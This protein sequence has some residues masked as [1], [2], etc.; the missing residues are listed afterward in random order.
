MSGYIPDE[1]IEEI[2]S[3]ADIREIVSAFVTLQKRGKYYTGLC[4]FHGEKKPSFTVNVERQ[5]FHCFGCGEGGN[6]IKFLMKINNMSFPEAV[7]FLAGKVGVDLPEREFREER[8]E[9]GK[10]EKLLGINRLAAG[11]FRNNLLQPENEKARAYLE[12]RGISPEALRRFSIGYARDGW[13]VLKDHLE[14]KAVSAVHGE[15]AGLL[16]RKDRDWFYDRFRDRIMFPVLDLNGN[17]VA[18]GGRVLGTGE[19]KYLN[20]PETAVY[21]KGKILYG[22]YDTKED[23]RQADRA[24]LVEGY[25]DLISLWQE[26]VRHVV[27][28]LGTALTR[29]Q[30]QILRRFTKNVVLLFDPDQAGRHAAE[31]SL[32]LFLEEGIHGWVL[33]LPEG[34]DPDT[35]IKKF[36]PERLCD[37]IRQAPSLTDYYIETIM[38]PGATLEEKL[39]RARNALPWIGSMDDPLQRNLFIR[40]IAEFL[41]VDAALL[42]REVGKRRPNKF[43]VK[44][45]SPPEPGDG[46]PPDP[47]ELSVVF[48]LM[49]YR[50]RMSREDMKKLLPYF[51]DP[52]AKRLAGAWVEACLGG[53]VDPQTFV[54]GLEEGET[55]KKIYEMMMG[56][57]PF[58]EDVADRLME[59]MTKKLRDRWFRFRHREI[60][61]QLREAQKQGDTER[62]QSLLQEKSRLLREE[63][64]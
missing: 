52:R 59:D 7:R 15:E 9:P 22:L 10:R 11:F 32:K 6:V 48:F 35:F 14:R 8:R 57:T 5:I 3:R 13:H 54:E 30:I 44:N 33:L 58:G 28:S 20:S 31:R 55:R 25:M 42:E 45:P 2:R 49:E 36:G 63:Q 12:A 34:Y 16:I 4:P 19:P 60:Q 40:R 62:C 47:L 29:E 18:F 23:I 24:I 50:S 21:T 26:G 43:A 39:E 56:E 64:S 17:V 51:L 37:L 38:G 27:A 61:H 46:P 53:G 1:K 41:G